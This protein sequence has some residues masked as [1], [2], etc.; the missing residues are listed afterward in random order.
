MAVSKILC[1][2]VAWGLIMILAA[3]SYSQEITWEAIGIRGG[4]NLKYVAI[5]PTED[6][7]FEQFDVFAIIRL[8]GSWHYSSGWEGSWRVNGSAGVIRGGETR[9]SSPKWGQ[10]S[11]F[12]KRIGG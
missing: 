4:M 11:R 1:V 9:A 12:A 10:A 7:D 8:P 6:H 5:P 2:L 3:P